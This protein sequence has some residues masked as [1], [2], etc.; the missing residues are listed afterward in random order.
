MAKHLPA[1]QS[2]PPETQ[3]A[4]ADVPF[5]RL[6]IDGG[7]REERYL[8]RFELAEGGSLRAAMIV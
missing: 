8:L 4:A 1:P 5:V 6:R 7:N 2:T 3:P